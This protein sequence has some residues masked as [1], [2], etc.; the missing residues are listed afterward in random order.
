VS[1]AVAEGS[2][3]SRHA[4]RFP[5][6]VLEALVV[7]SV[8]GWLRDASQIV[9]HLADGDARP[10]RRRLRQ[11]RELADQLETAPAESVRRCIDRIVVRNDRITIALRLDAIGLPSDSNVEA[12]VAMIEVP[13][14]LQRSGM[15]VRLIVHGPRGETRRSPDAKLVGLLAKAQDWLGRLTS[16]RSTS[17]AAIAA[18]AGVGAWY[19]T[20]VMYLA[21]LAPDIVQRIVRG[22]HPPAITSD[23]LIRM[24]PLPCDWTAQRSL[25]GFS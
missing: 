9:G 1:R 22:E 20:R 7:S 21:L 14:R 12:A 15:A 10:L 17:I 11:A 3:R 24:T 16:G 13:A 18:E 6:Q 25:L 8:I 2:Q 4:L 23:R 19:V 5:A